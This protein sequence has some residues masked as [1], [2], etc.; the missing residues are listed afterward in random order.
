[1][2]FANSVGPNGPVLAAFGMTFGTPP[3]LRKSQH[4]PPPCRK[5]TTSVLVSGPQLIA[6]PVLLEL[7][8]YDSFEASSTASVQ[9]ASSNG[10]H[11]QPGALAMGVPSVREMAAL[12]GGV[13][14]YGFGALG[15]EP[16]P[17]AAAA[18]RRATA[19]A[20]RGMV[21]IGVGM[22]RSLARAG[23]PRRSAG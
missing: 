19:S 14:T 4:A 6:R 22:A 15:L 10:T 16:S 5:T 8:W 1:M 9:N 7:N 17:H 18:R 11:V 2:S 13:P 3:Q 12:V 20:R 21:G 23:A